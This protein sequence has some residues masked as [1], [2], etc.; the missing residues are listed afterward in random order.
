MIKNIEKVPLSVHGSLTAPGLAFVLHFNEPTIAS[1][2]GVRRA[3]SLG[4][5]LGLLYVC[6]CQ[7]F[8]SFHI[9]L[10]LLPLL[11]AVNFGIKLLAANLKLIAFTLVIPFPLL[12]LSFSP[13]GQHEGQTSHTQPC[14]ARVNIAAT[15]ANASSRL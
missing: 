5:A 14:H 7:P 11:V 10:L 3:S 12:S 9:L 8:T 1:R 4:L 15:H 6:V 13:V 2:V